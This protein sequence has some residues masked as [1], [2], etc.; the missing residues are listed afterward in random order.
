MEKELQDLEKA[1]KHYR[2]CVDVCA[3]EHIIGNALYELMI[4]CNTV[5]DNCV[6]MLEVYSK[7]L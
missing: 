4:A 6:S 7:F 2:E 5:S 1:I 3:A